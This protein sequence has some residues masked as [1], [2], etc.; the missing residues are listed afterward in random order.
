M[1]YQLLDG[2]SPDEVLLDD[3][4]HVLL[5]H[6]VIPDAFWLYSHYSPTGAG[7]AALPISEGLRKHPRSRTDRVRKY[8]GHGRHPRSHRLD[9]P[10]P[11]LRK[12]FPRLSPDSHP[13]GSRIRARMHY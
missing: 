2:P 8:R 11:T 5:R 4:V 1:K 3:S 7:P 12:V 6:V 10:P 9:A 13:H